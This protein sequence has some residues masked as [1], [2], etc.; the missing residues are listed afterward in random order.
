[1]IDVSQEQLAPGEEHEGNAY[2]SVCLGLLLHNKA[3]VRTSCYI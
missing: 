2:G 3:L 1:M